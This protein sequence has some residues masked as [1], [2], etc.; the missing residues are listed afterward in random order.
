M[1]FCNRLQ[2]LCELALPEEGEKLYKNKTFAQ[3]LL[4]KLCQNYTT[5][6]QKTNKL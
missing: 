3:M 2:E 5:F 6:M 1:A 4:L